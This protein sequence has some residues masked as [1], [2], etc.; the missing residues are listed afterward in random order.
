MQQYYA[1]A[2][3][4]ELLNDVILSGTKKNTSSQSRNKKGVS[5]GNGFLVK[6][7][8]LDTENENLPKTIRP[9]S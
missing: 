8:V 3:S 2:S 1:V 7:D 6:G 9:C 4:I 5:I